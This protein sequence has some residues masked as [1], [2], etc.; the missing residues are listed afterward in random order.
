MKIFHILF[1]WVVFLLSNIA[2]AQLPYSQ[3]DLFYERLWFCTDRDVY[4]SGDEVH[5]SLATVDG[6]Y[7]API[8][9]SSVA[10]VEVYSQDNAPIVQKKS[11]L[12]DGR[13]NLSFMLPKK[14]STDFYYIRAYTNYQKN[15][16]AVSFQTKK[17][18]IINPFEIIPIT[19]ADPFQPDSVSE[20][21]SVLRNEGDTLLLFSADT[22]I[23]ILHY[24]LIANNMTVSGILT[25]Q[26]DSNNVYRIPLLG[27]KGAIKIDWKS[28]DT[29]S[30]KISVSRASVSGVGSIDSLAIL[31]DSLRA[32]R[33][34]CVSACINSHGI[35]DDTGVEFGGLIAVPDSFEFESEL[36]GDILY[37]AVS[38]AEGKELPHK[39]FI[40]SPN[41][42]DF[43]IAAS[44]DGIGN[45]S[46]SASDF[47]RH[48]IFI[49][50]PEDT[51]SSIQV[52]LKDEF[53]PDFA[54][55]DKQT[56]HPEKRLADYVKALMVFVQLEDAFRSPLS[57]DSTNSHLFYGNY[58]EAVVFDDYIN[59]PIFEDY[60]HELMPS[61]YIKKKRKKKHVWISDYDYRGFIGGNPLLLI[62]G[63]PYF[64]HS[65][66]VNLDPKIVEKI[67]VVN[68]KLSYLGNSFDGVLDIRLK[69]FGES[70]VDP[71]SNAV[72]FSFEEAG[73][74]GKSRETNLPRD[75]Q[76]VPVWEPYAEKGCSSE[77]I[78]CLDRSKYFVRVHGIR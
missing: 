73:R 32:N 47:D 66:V 49:A 70:N 35:F 25:A 54:T 38:Q 36:Y 58:D 74:E 56:Y 24:S 57:A 43:F 64:D 51:S 21:I 13:G 37:G 60:V 5:V 30:G 71:V 17:L 27:C 19:T 76:V 18:R 53:F 42:L 31:Q 63:V 2:I 33:I 23:G 61:V 8:C 10:Y 3:S 7:F 68:H 41:E 52:F 69:E 29:L 75:I 40:S 62:N 67:M 16:G 28:G 34:S 1:Y 11:A 44:V 72:Q 4:V 55:V 26:N 48:E 59:L 50:V 6:V 78:Q 9:Y 20:I 39:I 15:F 46:V 22:S 14:M 65:I 77:E 45:F 12:V